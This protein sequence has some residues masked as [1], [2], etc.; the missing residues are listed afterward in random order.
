MKNS[1]KK[2]ENTFKKGRKPKFNV[3]DIKRL[4]RLQRLLDR[5]M[6]IT[7]IAKLEGVSRSTLYRFFDRNQGLYKKNGNH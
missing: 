3:S 6:N 1:K 5:Q 2:S 4:K 7:E